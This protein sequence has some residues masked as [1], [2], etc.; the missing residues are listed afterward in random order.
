MTEPRIYIAD[1]AAYNNSILRGV[2]IDASQDLDSIQDDINAMLAASPEPNAEEY[3]IHDYEGFEGLD[4]HEYESLDYVQK[5]ADFISE[6]GELGAE[7]IKHFTD[8]EEARAALLDSYLGQYES[9]EDYAQ[10]T[11]Q[12]T[13]EVPEF[14]AYYVDYKSMGRDWEMSGDIFTIALSHSEV[15]IFSGR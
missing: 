13:H 6:H 1:L 15:H 5:L 14:L 8:I 10:Q 12:D 2:W 9:V 3:A 4:I 7:L 11:T